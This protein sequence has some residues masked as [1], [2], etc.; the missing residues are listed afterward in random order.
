MYPYIQQF[1]PGGCYVPDQQV[2]T[3]AMGEEGGVTTQA[4]NEEGGGVSIIWNEDGGNAVSKRT[5]DYLQVAAD[6]DRRGVSDGKLTLDELD[7]QISIY[8]RQKEVIAQVRELFGNANPYLDSY[9]QRLARVVEDKLKVA[10]RMKI[11]FDTI[12]KAHTE[13][14]IINRNDIFSVA[15]RDGR[16][17]DISDSD[18]NI[19]TLHGDTIS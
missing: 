3:L 12:D 1:A 10:D 14:G 13:D 11:N 2:T 17:Y 8:N 7:S 15:R 6:A 9:F 4:L 18:L 19:I 5:V 16:I